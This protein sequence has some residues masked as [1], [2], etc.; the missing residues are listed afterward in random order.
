MTNAPELLEQ[1]RKGI[2]IARNRQEQTN[3]GQ[4][5]TNE[6]QVKTTAGQT[7]TNEGQT[8]STTD[9]HSFI[10]RLAGVLVEGRVTIVPTS[11]LIKDQFLIVDYLLTYKDEELYAQSAGRSMMEAFANLLCTLSGSVVLDAPSGTGGSQENRGLPAE[12]G[13]QAGVRRHHQLILQSSQ[14]RP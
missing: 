13:P 7:Q 8:E 5:Q 4:T 14:P 10:H 6:G 9:N 3:E 12:Q 2:K 11:V 1:I